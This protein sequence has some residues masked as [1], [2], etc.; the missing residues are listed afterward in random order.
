M[1]IKAID[2]AGIIG[3]I[4]TIIVLGVL[5]LFVGM[6]GLRTWV[7]GAGPYAPLAFIV[8]KASTVIIAPLSGGPVYP[9]V[10]ALFGYWP[11]ILYTVIGD[12][13]GYA[14]AFWLARLFGR[15]Y[16]D[17]LVSDDEQGLIARI[18]RHMSTL[19]GL[20]HACFTFFAMPEI[21]CYAGGLSRMP[22]WKFMLVLMPLG[23]IASSILVFAG[24]ILGDQT[25]LVSI[26]LPVF[27]LFVVLAGGW[28]FFLGVKDKK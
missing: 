5:G 14:G 2:H 9:L 10:G 27:G 1:K 7:E 17:K 6:D 28:L 21:I 16:V 22:F 12:F 19:K 20:V 13:I 25:L 15:K 26:A 3:A 8:L 4:G 11:G 23:V 18:V 24:A